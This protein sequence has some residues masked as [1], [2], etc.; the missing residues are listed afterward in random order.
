MTDEI[1]FTLKENPADELYELLKDI[2]VEK[3]PSFTISDTH[4]NIAEYVKV[5][6][7]KDCRWFRN[8]DEG[9]WCVAWAG[10]NTNPDAFC[11]YAQPKERGR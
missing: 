7:C 9:T 2:D 3:T 11:S 8:D 6:R 5:I 1:T 10:Q 4:G